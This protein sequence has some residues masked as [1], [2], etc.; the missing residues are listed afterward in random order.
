LTHTDPDAFE[1]GRN[2]AT[3]PG[4]VVHETPLFQLIQYSPTTEGAGGAAGDLS[5]V[6][7]PVLHPRPQP[8]EKLHPLGG[9]TGAVGVH[10]LVE[11]GRCLDGRGAVGRLHPRAGRKRSTWCARG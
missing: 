2:L 7:Q 6:D 10:R 9:R 1:L 8:A 4:K 3:T 5:A 11:I